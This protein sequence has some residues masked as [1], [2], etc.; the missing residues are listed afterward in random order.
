VTASLKHDRG[1]KLWQ[2]AMTSVVDMEAVTR[3]LAPMVTQ[4]PAVPIPRHIAVRIRHNAR[5]FDEKFSMLIHEQKRK[6]KQ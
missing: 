3:L 6:A 4:F 5:R 1:W 2:A